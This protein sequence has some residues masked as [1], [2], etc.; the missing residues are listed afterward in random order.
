MCVLGSSV[1]IIEENPDVRHLLVEALTNEGGFLVQTARTIPEAQALMADHGESFAVALLDISVRDDES[2]SF[3]ASLR[4]Q[5]FRLPVILLNGQHHG[6][7]VI[8][9]FKAGADDYLLKPFG[10]AELLACI[11]TQLRHAR[12][13]STASN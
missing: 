13:G 9:G 12:P 8:R 7:D 10:I 2:L 4:R 5:G 1:L 6:D 11:A 3:C